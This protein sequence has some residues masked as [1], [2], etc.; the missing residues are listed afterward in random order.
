MQRI[1]NWST[2][3]QSSNGDCQTLSVSAPALFILPIRPVVGR[4]W[5]YNYKQSRKKMVMEDKILIEKPRYILIAKER[6][7]F[8][9]GVLQR[10]IVYS[11]ID[12]KLFERKIHT[13]III[14]DLN[15]PSPIIVSAEIFFV[16]LFLKSTLSRVRQ[17][18]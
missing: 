1:K 12:H 10:G 15:R 3:S 6:S 7:A 11:N 13:F 2:I 17:K 14:S 4:W 9:R 16:H 18:I 5:G 8:Y